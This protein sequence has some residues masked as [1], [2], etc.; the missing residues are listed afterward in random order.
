MKKLYGKYK[1]IICMALVIC[2]M[3]SVTS[4]SAFASEKN[5]SSDTGKTKIEKEINEE[6]ENLGLNIIAEHH[7]QVPIKLTKELID[8]NKNI[9]TS[10]Q[11][12]SGVVMVDVSWKISYT[13]ADGLG[14]YTNASG[15]GALLKKMLGMNKWSGY[16]SG[17]CEIRTVNT[18]PMSKI[19]NYISTGKH[20]P[21]GTSINCSMYVDI[22]AVNEISGGYFSASDIVKIP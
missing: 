12:S 4:I 5:A 3:I 17:G 9:I 21:S 10:E 22:D 15:N 7:Y 18:V 11:L 2:C 8:N 14:F 6:I 13:E 1:K 19:H 16:G 20:L